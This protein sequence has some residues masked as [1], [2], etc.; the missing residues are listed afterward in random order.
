MILAQIGCYVPAASATIVLR[1]RIL[2]RIGTSDDL[3]NNMSTFFMECKDT[4]YILE[5]ITEQSLVII[6]ELVYSQSLNALYS[7]HRIAL[8]RDEGLQTS[9]AFR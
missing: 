9:T 7:P 6:D 3:E 2:S 5:N 4:A 1:D 8:F